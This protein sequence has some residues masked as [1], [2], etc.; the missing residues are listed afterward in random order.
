MNVPVVSKR[1]LALACR[2]TVLSQ[3]LLA[4]GISMYDLGHSDEFKWLQEDPSALFRATED[5][6]TDAVITLREDV[7]RLQVRILSTGEVYELM[8]SQL[9]TLRTVLRE[10]SSLYAAESVDPDWPEIDPT[11]LNGPRSFGN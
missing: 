1:H 11:L 4:A 6:L 2:F 8:I 3:S 10:N 5:L 7:A 9:A